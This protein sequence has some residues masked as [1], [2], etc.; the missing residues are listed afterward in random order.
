MSKTKKFFNDALFYSAS[1]IF[2]NILNFIT[3][4]AVR[5]LLQ[6]VLMG[7]LSEIMLI[8]EYVRY[9]HLGIINALDKELP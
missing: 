3:G 4:I 8:F 9:S 6:P 1:N 2:A 5:R 7:L